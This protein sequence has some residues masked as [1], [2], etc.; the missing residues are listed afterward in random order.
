MMI[1]SGK[2]LFTKKQL[3]LV[4]SS[5]SSPAVSSCGNNFMFIRS[6][7]SLVESLKKFPDDH[8]DLVYGRFLALAL[9]HQDYETL[10]AECWRVCKPRGFVEF[11]ELD[12]RIYGHSQVSPLVQRLNHQVISTMKK[13][14]LDPRLPRHMQDLF[15]KLLVD[16]RQQSYQVNYN[17]LPLGVWGGRLGVMFRD[18]MHDVLEALGVSTTDDPTHWQA[19]SD[20]LDD[21]L[22]AQMAFMN[23]YQIFVQKTKVF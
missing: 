1:L 18:D 21:E 20:T 6:T 15:F 22:D 23:L 5:L 4:S 7:L 17:S 11:T 8:F 9:S 3:G 12:M 19:S 14:N 16:A 10:V 2:S 13:K